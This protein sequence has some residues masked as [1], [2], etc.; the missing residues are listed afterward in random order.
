[1]FAQRIRELRTAKDISQ[2]DLA[3]LVGKTQQAIYFWEKGDNEPAYDILIKLADFFSVS[4]DYLL[5]RAAIPQIRIPILGSIRAGIPILTE[6]NYG[7]Y[8]DV[9]GSIRADFALRVVG[10]SMI[11]V[12][13]LDGDYAICREN[14]E[15]QTGQ[16]IVALHD[17]GSTS[18]ATLKFYFNGSGQPKLR[19]AN[20]TYP[21][22]DYLKG[23]RCAGHMVALMRQDAPGYQTYKDYLTVAGHEEWTE[24][25]ELASQ[26]GLKVSQVKEILAGQID[27]AKRL[28]S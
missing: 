4:V 18:E 19:A 27:I 2:Q 5:G 17:E 13:I 9:P 10:N 21:D 6:E 26:A 15:P 12:G 28:R 14:E 8:L 11:G 22:I 23:Y 1:M 20:P 25:I 3:N 7:G 24:V 16:I